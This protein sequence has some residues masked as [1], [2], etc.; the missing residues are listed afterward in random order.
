MRSLKG[1]SVVITGASSGIGRAAAIAFAREGAN[2][3]LTARR[4]TLLDEAVRECKRQGGRAISVPA[5]VTNASTLWRGRPWTASGKSMSGS[6]TLAL[7][8]SAHTRTRA[9]ICTAR[10]SIQILSAGC[11]ALCGA[12]TFIRQG[13]GILIKQYLRR[14]LGACPVCGILHCKQVRLAWLLGDPPAGADEISQHPGLLRIPN[15]CRYA[16]S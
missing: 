2:L 7:A 10:P 12:A 3:T 15:D 6:T 9:S 11:T 1:K 5:D 16:W 13:R 14:R 4:G 8:S